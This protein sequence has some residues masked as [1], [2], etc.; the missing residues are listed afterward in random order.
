MY[1]PLTGKSAGLH[2]IKNCH[3]PCEKNGLKLSAPRVVSHFGVFSRSDRTVNLDV[4]SENLL[5]LF[6]CL[7]I[8]RVLRNPINHYTT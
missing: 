1:H 7:L 4:N 5:C 2:T 6:D 3:D 8:T